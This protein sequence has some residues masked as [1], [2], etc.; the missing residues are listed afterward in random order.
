[1]MTRRTAFT[2]LAAIWAKQTTV[3]SG[4]ATC[5]WPTTLTLDLGAGACT[6]K[7]LRVEQG[8]LSAEV[9]V[10]DLIAALKQ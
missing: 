3:W 2:L 6:V 7:R 5:P 4:R 9:S 10:E 1:M 8:A